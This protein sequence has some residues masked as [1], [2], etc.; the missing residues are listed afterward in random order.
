MRKGFALAWVLLLPLVVNAQQTELKVQAN[1]FM[2]WTIGKIVAEN[3]DPKGAVLWDVTPVSPLNEDAASIFEMNGDLYFTGPPGRYKVICT[4]ITIVDN[5][6]Q[7]RRARKTI[8]ILAQRPLPPPGPTPNPGP[9]PGPVTK[10]EVAAIIIEETAE[11]KQNRGAYL[12]DQALFDFFSKNGHALRTADKD[13]KGPDKKTP[14]SDW[15]PY[16]NM[17]KGKEMPY[18]IIIPKTGGQTLWTGAL[19]TE[20]AGLIALIRQVGGK[21]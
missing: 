5:K 4:E 2:E 11:A 9:Q 20:P 6:P 21:G 12:S 7:P 3:R 16:L 10:V 8:E 13:V 19:P 17:A 15:V 18:L 1:S 14:P